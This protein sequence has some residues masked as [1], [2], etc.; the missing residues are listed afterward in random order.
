MK[1]MLSKCVPFK[2]KKKKK[3]FAEKKPKVLSNSSLSFHK[4]NI[5][6][7]KPSV[8]QIIT[9]LSVIVFIILKIR[10]CWNI[11]HC[12]NLFSDHTVIL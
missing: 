10:Q 7:E 8:V 2:K 11:L 3:E 9:I 6:S 5:Y 12:Q 4:F 1:I